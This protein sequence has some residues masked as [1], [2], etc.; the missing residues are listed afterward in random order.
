MQKASLL[1]YVSSSVI[2]NLHSEPEFVNGQKLYLFHTAFCNAKMDFHQTFIRNYRTLLV[3]D[4]QKDATHLV[5]QQ[6][7]EYKSNGLIK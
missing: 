5:D 6:S 4:I 7:K 3:V 2:D 1:K